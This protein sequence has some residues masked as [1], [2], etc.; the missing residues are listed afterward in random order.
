MST[1]KKILVVV[2]HE[3]LFEKLEPL[4]RR[5]AIEIDRATDGLAAESLSTIT[6]YQ[7]LLI[8][9]PMRD[10]SVRKLLNSIRMEGYPSAESPALILAASERTEEL[11]EVFARE[12]DEV[13]SA[14]RPTAELQAVVSRMLGVAARA[15]TRILVQV[16]VS[17]ASGA[18]V[19]AY[20]AMNLSESGMLLRATRLMPVGQTVNLEFSLPGVSKLIRAEARVVRHTDPDL[21]GIPGMGM[22][23]LSVEREGARQ[24][25]DFVDGVLED[26]E[27]RRV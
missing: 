18:F 22:H 15:T 26:D 23:F 4:L 8:V 13:I 11:S 19:Q 27:T 24:L 12:K 14:A 10:M 17:V 6:P 21:E 2:P 1:S 3:E 7:L 5:S 16:E 20:Q 25:K 9:H